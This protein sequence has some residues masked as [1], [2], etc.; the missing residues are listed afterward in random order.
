MSYKEYSSVEEKLEAEL[1]EMKKDLEWALNNVD[2]V[3]DDS[4]FV[5]SE[6]NRIRTKWEIK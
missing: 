6:K 3:I 4:D 5:Y 1:E 2:T